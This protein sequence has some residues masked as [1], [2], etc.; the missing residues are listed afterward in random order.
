MRADITPGAAFPDYE[1]PDETDTPRRLSMLQGD[2]PMVLTLHRGYYC[3]KDR[4]QLHQLV[5]FARQCVVGYTRLV[6][7]TTDNSVLQLNE[8]RMGVGADWPFLYDA[9]RLIA[10]DL[11]IEE[12][13]DPEHHPMIPYTF[14]LEP[15]LEIFRI[16][17]GY[18][19]WGRPS[20]A[21]LHADLREISARIRP[22]WHIDSAAMREQWEL[23]DTDKFYPYGQSMRQ[24]LV[25]AAGA[26]DQFE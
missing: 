10:K 17:N 21:E 5:P 14:V 11:E 20:T 12:Y 15:G 1:L 8:L 4:Q 16:Y 3:P 7:I 9:D 6:S 2:D 18:W 22:D 13:T 26:V 19:Y 23:G 24:V 25:R